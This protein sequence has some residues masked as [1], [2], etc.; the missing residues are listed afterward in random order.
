MR[1]DN[2]I[3]SFEDNLAFLK[4]VA[5]RLASVDVTSATD[6]DKFISEAVAFRLFRAYE[7]FLRAIFL[8]ACTNA[9]THQGAS[10][11]SKLTCPDW[12][13]AESILKSGNR[14]LDW[15]NVENTKRNASLIFESGFPISD[16]L[17]PVHSDLVNLQKIRNFIA[18]DSQE[19]TNGFNKTIRN[20]LPA[21][22]TAIDS[23]GELLLSRRRPR[24]AQVLR[25]LVKKVDALSTIYKAL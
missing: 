23:A 24:D 20:Y 22:R 6:D 18:H 4:R 25:K 5:S 13:T 2:E 8:N 14:F 16:L 1:I 10:I 21:G 3:S 15:G 9:L 17:A 7:R 11:V 19:A 12:E